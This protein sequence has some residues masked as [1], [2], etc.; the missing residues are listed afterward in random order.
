MQYTYNIPNH[1]HSLG[2]TKRQ[3]PISQRDLKEPRRIPVIEIIRFERERAVRSTRRRAT[4]CRVCSVL[5]HERKRQHETGEDEETQSPEE[6]APPARLEV[7]PGVL[8]RVAPAGVFPRFG[9]HRYAGG[10]RPLVSLLQSNEK[11]V[12]NANMR[13]A[14]WKA[15]E[16]TG[17]RGCRVVYSLDMPAF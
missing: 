8:V 5:Q 14:D 2:L 6:P 17:Q 10:W 16:R 15:N 9:N 7:V 4:E 12:D 1:I 13:H 11:V 3:T